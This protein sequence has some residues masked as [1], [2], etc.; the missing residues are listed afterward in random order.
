MSDAITLIP[1]LASAGSTKCISAISGVFTTGASNEDAYTNVSIPNNSI[2]AFVHLSTMLGSNNG[3]ADAIIP[4]N[5]NSYTVTNYHYGG[6]GS[7]PVYCKLNENKL[8]H[9]LGYSSSTCYYT[10]FFYE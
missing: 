2:F 5:I 8:H 3:I 6:T 4:V 10:I 9:K 7:M 1:I